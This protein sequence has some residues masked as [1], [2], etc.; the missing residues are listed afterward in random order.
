MGWNDPS[1]GRDPWGR[2][3]AGAFDLDAMVRNLWRRVQRFYRRTPPP[4]IFSSAVILIGLIWVMSGFYIVPQGERAVL[5][6]FGHEVRLVGPG[7][8]WR[9]P[10][11]FSEDQLVNIQR[12]RVVTIGYPRDRKRYG[13]NRRL[14]QASMLTEHD[15]IVHLE[16]AVQYRVKNPEKYLFSVVHPR[17]TVAEAAEATMREVIGHVTLDAVL[18]QHQ[19]QIERHTA[20]ALQAILNQ[21]HSGIE[22]VAVKIQKA[23]PPKAVD[24]AFAQIVIA[25]EAQARMR[26]QAETYADGILPKAQGDAVI[27]IDHARAYRDTVISKAQGRTS[28]FLALGQAYARAP[29]ITRRRLYISAMAKVYSKVPKIYL[30]NPGNTVVHVPSF[31]GNK[32]APQAVSRKP[33]P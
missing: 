26:E 13:Y 19:R 25:R 5:T 14:R 4:R 7:P 29:L 1:G 23:V 2:R 8:H 24:S 28:R 21:Y 20:V 12:I 15:S 11:P 32:R 27:L 16:F 30:S 31:F 6:V 18:T 17:K 9:W 10:R 22:I 3:G 33:Q